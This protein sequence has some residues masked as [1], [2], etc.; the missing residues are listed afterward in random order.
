MIKRNKAKAINGVF[1]N[2]VY[3][4]C[5]NKSCS[6]NNKLSHQFRR[7]YRGAVEVLYEFQCLKE[8]YN[9]NNNIPIISIILNQNITFS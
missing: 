1:G 7:C 5:C 3:G 2:N 6:M 8:Y 4:I 9:T